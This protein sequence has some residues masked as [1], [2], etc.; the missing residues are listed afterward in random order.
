VAVAI[1]A[2]ILGA[3]FVLSLVLIKDWNPDKGL[4]LFGALASPLAAMVT[5]YFGIQ[6]SQQVAT[7]AQE[8]AATAQQ[9]AGEADQRATEAQQQAGQADQRAASAAKEA[10]QAQAEAARA[11]QQVLD[12]L[13]APVRSLIANALRAEPA[14]LGNLPPMPSAQAMSDTIGAADPFDT[15]AASA[16]EQIR[17]K[18]ERDLSN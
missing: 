3:A 12:K 15:R 11:P 17:S 10:E 2:G 7:Q 5:A 1:G 18:V 4:A 13:E 9:Q 6:A 16:W 8:Q 14:S